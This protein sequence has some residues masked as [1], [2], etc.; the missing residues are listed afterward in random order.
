MAQ[1]NLSPSSE[2]LMPT[3]PSR[4]Q[5]RAPSEDQTFSKE[6]VMRKLP[7]RSA[8]FVENVKAAA[9]TLD[10][11]W[12]LYNNVI[13]TECLF[14]GDLYGN[15]PVKL[16]RCRLY[17]CKV[18]TGGN[19]RFIDAQ[20][21]ECEIIECTFHRVEMI[22]VRFENCYFLRNHFIYGTIF[23][24][25]R[26]LRPHGLETNI[27]LHF[28]RNEGEAELEE[29]LR[30]APL[31]LTEKFASWERLRTLGLLPLFGVSFS[32]LVVIPIVVFLIGTYN[33]QVRRLQDWASSHA[34]KLPPAATSLLE[35]LASRLHPIPI[36]NLT[37]WLLISTFL[38]GTASMLYAL[39]CPARVKEFSLEG[40]T[41]EIG[42]SGLHYLPLS[43]GHRWV[44]LIVG[45]CYL[46]GGLGTILILI[47]KLINAGKFI[48]ANTTV[49][50]WQW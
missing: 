24:R 49:H 48:V 46:A 45:V 34:E 15:Q 14:D 32:A 16:E 36:P 18:G 28:V 35:P 40:W 25:T 44:R 39:F 3:D 33:E 12:S 9:I 19:T 23:T 31:P 17:K 30:H 10:K 27:N 29:D 2:P 11:L 22:N 26:L 4:I 47:V 41:N 1:R 6:A 42:R 13:Y 43:W 21:I 8:P 20:F 5:S 37:F 38:L 50:W 7:K